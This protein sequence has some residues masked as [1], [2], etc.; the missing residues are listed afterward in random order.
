MVF[1]SD[2]LENRKLLVVVGVVEVVGGLRRVRRQAPEDAGSLVVVAGVLR[3]DGQTYL[4]FGSGGG[5]K[6]RLVVKC[7]EE[8]IGAK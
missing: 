6:G 4:W 7:G 8:E 5:G 3:E 1:F 2:I